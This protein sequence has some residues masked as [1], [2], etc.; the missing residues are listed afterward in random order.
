ME[1]HNPN[2]TCVSVQ[3]AALLFF[4][5]GADFAIADTFTVSNTNQTGA[6]SLRQ[7]IL[8]ANAA[9]GLDTIVFAIRSVRRR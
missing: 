3:R 8:D 5:A 9:P 7:A 4:L 2:P 1:L 6:G